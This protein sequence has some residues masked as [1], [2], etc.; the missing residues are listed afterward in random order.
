M[1]RVMTIH[2]TVL[3]GRGR[4]RITMVVCVGALVALGSAG[5]AMAT[6]PDDSTIE[7]TPAGTAAPAEMASVEVTL[8]DASIDG[9]PDDLI[10]GV[11]DITVTD[12]T[13][14]AGGAVS[15]TMVETGTD[16][17]TF[18]TGLA[19]LFAGGPFPDYWLNLAGVVGHS[20]ITL[21]AGEYFVWIDRPST[22][23]DIIAVPLTVGAGDNDAVIPPTDGGHI[24]AGDYLFDAD[25]TGGGTTVTFT[26]SS[27]NQFHHVAVIDW[28]TN[29]PAL[30]EGYLPAWI[31]SHGQAPP[32]E[33]IDPEQVNPDFADTPIFGPGS[34]GTFEAPFE[35]GHT[36]SVMCLVF[37]REGDP[38]HAL[39]HQMYDVFQVGAA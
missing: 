18:K 38:P 5:T 32:P 33:G 27:D 16:V 13:D 26:N 29:D 31:E 1:K 22:V 17:E 36:Y 2:K 14:G 28:G 37:D 24:R 12:E 35:E 3:V 30:V 11:V 8:T 21:D 20:M 4:R 6:T 19:A 9:L 7:T 25:V 10:A 15:F 23:D 39:Q 34:S